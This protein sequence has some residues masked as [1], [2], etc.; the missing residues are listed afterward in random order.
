MEWCV[1]SHRRGVEILRELVRET[2]FDTA[3]Q[4]RAES[5]C[6]SHLRHQSPPHGRGWQGRDH[7]RNVYGLSAKMPLLSE[8]LH[9]RSKEINSAKGRYDRDNRLLII[10]LLVRTIF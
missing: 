4:R 3:D 10:N 5:L 9:N 8:Q 7:P 1:R 2:I 6:Q